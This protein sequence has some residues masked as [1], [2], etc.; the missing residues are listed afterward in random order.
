MSELRASYYHRAYLE[1]VMEIPQELT[2][3][4]WSTERD[5]K[6]TLPKYEAGVLTTRGWCSGISDEIDVQIIAYSE[7]L[8]VA[9]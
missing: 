9:L 1:E 4:S 3:N 5:L 6:S 7:V 2:Q 8:N